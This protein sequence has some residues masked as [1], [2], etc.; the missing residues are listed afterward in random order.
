MAGISWYVGAPSYSWRADFAPGLATARDPGSGLWGAV[1]ASGSWV[2]A[3]S[4][5]ELGSPGDD[6]LVPARSAG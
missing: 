4:F 2:L 6:G 5:A 3:P 1:D